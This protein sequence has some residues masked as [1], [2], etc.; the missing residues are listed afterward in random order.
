[1]GHGQGILPAVRLVEEITP[2]R[3]VP[4]ALE[5]GGCIEIGSVLIVRMAERKLVQPG[6]VLV[7]RQDESPHAAVFIIRPPEIAPGARTLRIFLGHIIFS[8][9]F[10]DSRNGIVTGSIFQCTV[11]SPGDAPGDVAQAAVFRQAPAPFRLIVRGRHLGILAHRLQRQGIVDTL[12]TLGKGVGDHDFRIGPALRP[13]IGVAAPGIGQVAVVA[14]NGQHRIYDVPFPLRIQQGDQ[15]Q[16]CAVGIPKGIEIII[17][18]LFACRRPLP[19]PVHGHQHRVVEPRVEHPF[20]AQGC[21]PGQRDPGEK[22]LPG[23]QAGGPRRIE[24]HPGSLVEILPR[25]VDAQEGN[26]DPEMDERTETEVHFRPGFPFGRLPEML[27]GKRSV[28]LQAEIDRI[29]SAVVPAAADALPAR[30]GVFVVDLAERA[31]ELLGLP[32]L[33][34]GIFAQEEAQVHPQAGRDSVRIANPVV[35]HPG[36]GGNLRPDAVFFIFRR[37]I[38]GQDGLFL[39]ME[40]S[41]SRVVRE[42]LDEDVAV[43]GS[44]AGAAHMDLRKSVHLHRDG[45]PAA[46]G[47]ARAVRR[48]LHH[49]ERAGRPDEGAAQAFR[50]DPR[51]D[52]IRQRPLSAGQKQEQRQQPPSTNQ[53]PVH[54]T[55]LPSI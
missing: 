40:D 54:R 8:E 27:P 52:V 16:R 38:S 4:G 50:A 41:G 51:V 9:A 46:V 48:G 22:F 36:R 44:P 31:F 15:R 6:P 14:V 23:R 55:F 37:I 5:G 33:R 30:D 49:P 13:A 35:G 32:G 21:A 43:F 42:R 45:Q 12:Q 53:R 11:A 25:L 20:F 28:A 19:R 17:I 2:P 29:G 3:G 39:A 34:H 1:M 26:A 10:R 24:V 18:D 47:R 7:A